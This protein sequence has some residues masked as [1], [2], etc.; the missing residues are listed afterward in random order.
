MP[1]VYRRALLAILGLIC[2]V[3][4][5]VVAFQQPF[6]LWHWVWLAMAGAFL[7]ALRRN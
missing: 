7:Y 3:I 6:G 2:V 1:P 5:V 4:S